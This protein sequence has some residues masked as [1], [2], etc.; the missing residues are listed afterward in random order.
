M[1]A[2]QQKMHPATR[3]FVYGTLFFGV[4]CF[5]IF[6]TRFAGG[7]ALVW[8]G[9]AIAAALFL[10]VPQ[11]RHLGTAVLLVG[12]STLATSVFGLGPEWAF[13]LAT[14]NI[15]EAWFIAWLLVR[16]RPERDYVD[17][18]QGI[19]WLGFLAGLAGPFAAAIP[20]S[21][22][23]MQVV[24]GNW[25]EHAFSW[26][27][28]HGLGTLLVLPLAL[29]LASYRQPIPEPIRGPGRLLPFF[30]IVLLTL[31]I[32][33]VAFLQS[34]VPT[35]FLPIVP[36]VLASFCFG[37]FGASV[38]VLNITVCAAVSLAMDVG[39]FAQLHLALWQKAL[40][41]QF[42]LSVLLLISFPLAV[43][44][45]QRQ[46]F[47][48]ELVDRE[49]MQRLIADHSDDALLHLDREGTIRFASPASTRLSGL[50]IVEG[51]PLAAFFS[52]F[53]KEIVASA[54]VSA[55]H[56][57]G[58]TEI[59]ERSVERS[60]QTR[61]LKAKLRA[62]DASKK[63]ASTFVVTIRDVTERK[64]NEIQISW[65]ARTDVLT[66]LPNRRAFLDVPEAQLEFADEQPFGF[67]LIDLDHFKRVNDSYG[68]AVGDKVLKQV[69][70][71]MREN[72]TDDCF[73]ARLGGEEFGL[74]A[75]GSALE[76]LSI[77]CERLRLAILRSA[78]TDNDGGH[79][80]ITMSIGIAQISE[81]CSSSM[82]MQAADGPLYSAKAAGR[83]CIRHAQHMRHFAGS[84]VRDR[85][86]STLIAVR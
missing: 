74:I 28:G 69:A 79:F 52:E 11:S 22:V 49:A 85:S 23:V 58:H 33:A 29:L 76:T 45:K 38:T 48:E 19:V 81:R 3:I 78:M 77:I 55:A 42:Y 44:L 82:A 20:G 64:L 30:G 63:Q 32:S 6:W 37:R 26:G 51:L 12:L 67:A 66:G 80:N 50:E 16:F 27:V 86:S 59:I 17:S 47:M 71:I 35:L 65:E 84:S 40:F 2:A 31:T 39:V 43:A 4:T 56:Y 68:H 75:C 14:I 54:L 62:V 46:R 24:G 72:T 10:S 57:R 8:P 53:D 41:L 25:L 60:G 34:T 5:T 15:F 61:W 7:L 36:L 21:L 9:T 70:Q 1:A 18:E 13:P 73:F 83:N